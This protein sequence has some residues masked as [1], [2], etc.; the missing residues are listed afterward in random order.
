MCADFITWKCCT[1]FT[2]IQWPLAGVITADIIRA[3]TERTSEILCLSDN[4]GQEAKRIRCQ[5]MTK[6]KMHVIMHADRTCLA[7]SNYTNKRPPMQAPF[8]PTRNCFRSNTRRPL[9]L[10][11]FLAVPIL[12]IIRIAKFYM[13]FTE[14]VNT[15]ERKSNHMTIYTTT[16]TYITAS[17]MLQSAPSLIRTS[18]CHWQHVRIM[19]TQV[20]LRG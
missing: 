20:Q 1:L 5:Y 12:E 8:R 17:L 11:L 3:A 10:E 19:P 16:S 18:L 4:V 7:R 6:Q 2:C 9:A 14:Q 15:E 13:A